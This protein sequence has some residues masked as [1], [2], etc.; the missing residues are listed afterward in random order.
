MVRWMETSMPQAAVVEDALERIATG[1][2]QM[3][4]AVATES[5]LIL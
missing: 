2:E 1:L 4:E 3:Q 5:F